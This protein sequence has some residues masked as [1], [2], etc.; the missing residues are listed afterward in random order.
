VANLGLQAAEALDHAHS[1]GILHRDIKPANLLLD[2]GGRLWVTDFGLAQVQGN[3]GLTLSGDILGTL[4]YMSPEQAL[5]GRVVIDGRTDVYSLGVTLYE[6]LTLRPA[7]DG[8]DRQ[9][10]LRRIAE[11]EPA[12]P[13][14]LN[15][16]VPADLETIVLKATSTDPAARYVTAGDL[17]VD[18]RRFLEG[19]PIRARRPSLVDRAAKWSRRHRPVVMTAALLLV[20]GTVTS[21]WQAVRA[22]RAEAL[23]AGHAEETQLV[24][25]YLVQ[26][27]FG[28]ARPERSRGRAVT[29]YDLLGQGEVSIPARFGR[30]PLVEASARWALGET[31]QALGRYQDAAQQ[32]RR[33]AELRSR[34]LGPDHTETL[35]AE[36]ALVDALCPAGLGLVGETAEAEPI[37]RHVLEARRRFDPADRRTLASMAA[38]AYVL[39]NKAGQLTKAE[40]ART[41][42]SVPADV[43]QSRVAGITSEAR[44]LLGRA[45]ADQA[46]QLGPD[47]LETLETLEILGRVLLAEGDLARAESTFQRAAEVRLRVLGPEHPATLRVCK[48]LGATLRRKGSR[49]EATRLLSNV[50]EATRRTFGPFHIQTSSALGHLLEVLWQSGDTAAIRDL[51]ERWLREIRELPIDQDPYQLSRRAVRLEHLSIVLTTLRERIPSDVALA[52]RA[53][54]DAVAVDDN[55]YSWTILGTVYWRVGRPDDADRAL[56]IARERPD[57]KGG[58]GFYWVVQSL[59]HARRGEWARARECYTRSLADNHESW[60][61]LLRALR[62]DAEVLIGIAAPPADV[63]APP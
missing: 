59:L 11:R 1:H 33:V 8:R 48:Y 6:L 36:A 31:Y 22:T 2:V 38:L 44:D 10:I 17:A 42:G 14:R 26:D 54:E 34:H 32:F 5:G 27:V 15:P 43:R 16:A 19:Q 46:R 4:R 39:L 18:L 50:A 21:T 41:P 30:R 35:V 52:V 7:V 47:R 9:E 49:E 24:V 37:A 58:V 20:L 62:A 29:V 55:S 45:H 56:R 60:M 40:Q 12:P 13:R 25:D 23:A 51:C 53:A 63:F 3:T 57:W 28:A 61:D